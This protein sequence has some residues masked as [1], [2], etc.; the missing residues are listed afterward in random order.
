MLTGIAYPI[1]MAKL[2]NVFEFT[3]YRQ[4]LAAYFAERKKRDRK[5]SHR[6]FARR[7]G[8]RSPVFIMLVMRAERNITSSLAFRVSEEL[9]HIQREAEYFESLVGFDQAKLEE[10]LGV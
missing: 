1:G 5:F 9:K 2:V 4:Y 10:L 7:L 3:D 6:Y 8:L